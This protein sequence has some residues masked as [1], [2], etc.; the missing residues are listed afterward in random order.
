MFLSTIEK[1]IRWTLVWAAQFLQSHKDALFSSP[2][3]HEAGS[4]KRK[5][6][7]EV[8]VLATPGLTHSECP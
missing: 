2:Q 7:E 8:T 5:D 3:G 1:Q 4:A 6:P